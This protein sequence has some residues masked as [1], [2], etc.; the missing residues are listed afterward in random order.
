MAAGALGFSTSKG[1]AHNGYD[2]HPVPSRRATNDEIDQLTG[3]MA[4]SGGQILEVTPS[5]MSPDFFIDELARIA[6]KHHCRVSWGALFG[7]V[8][9]PKSHR[10]LLERTQ[11]LQAKGAQVIPQVSARAFV[12]DF[13]FLQPYPFESRD[14]FKPTMKTDLAGKMRMYA[15]PKFRATFREDLREGGMHAFAGWYLRTVISRNPVDP[16]MENKPLLEAA[17]ESGK[18]VIDFVLDLSLQTH[19]EA[20]FRMAALNFDEEDVAELLDHADTDCVIG[21]SDA[22]AH[23]S[24]LCDACYSTYML[25]HWVREKGIMSLER[26]IHILT[27]RPA[28]VYGLRDRGTLAVGRAADIVIF[29][30]K[31]IHAGELRR[32]RDLPGG[33]ERLIADAFGID[34]VIVNGVVLR[35]NGENQ[36]T[37]GGPLPGALLRGGTA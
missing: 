15:D 17:R 13:N 4:Q 10:G 34:K 23:A 31:T 14:Y 16:T 8:M 12:L 22:G 35:S 32:V 18:D 5:F 1:E 11:A 9:G 37:A 21:V 25:G 28:Q 6:I 30:P 29:D 26:A 24:Q 19:L 3:V 33:G 27:Q 7:G 2:G 36:V 20:R